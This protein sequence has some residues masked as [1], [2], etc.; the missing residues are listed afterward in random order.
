MGERN[1]GHRRKRNEHEVSR[2]LGRFRWIEENA[3]IPNSFAAFAF[4][5]VQLS[6]P[7]STQS[8]MFALACAMMAAC[9]GKAVERVTGT[10]E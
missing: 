2:L 8:I 1:K 7:L 4:T 9:L 5:S 6:L 10:V 3:T